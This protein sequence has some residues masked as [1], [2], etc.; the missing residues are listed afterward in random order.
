MKKDNSTTKIEQTS[1][2][3]EDAGVD[4]FNFKQ[5]RRSQLK[6][7]PFHTYSSH[8]HA[9]YHASG[10]DQKLSDSRVLK[11]SSQNALKIEGKD[12]YVS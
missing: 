9:Y 12:R 6:N 4:K 3:N 7:Y 1:L 2:P 10:D 8:M 5:I 11:K